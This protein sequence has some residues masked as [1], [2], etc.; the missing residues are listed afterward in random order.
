MQNI[1]VSERRGGWVAVEVLSGG[2]RGRPRRGWARGTEQDGDDDWEPLPGDV[3]D[4]VKW[5]LPKLEELQEELM[6][7]RRKNLL[8]SLT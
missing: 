2:R 6:D 5:R 4:G 1:W 7:R 3:G 8:E